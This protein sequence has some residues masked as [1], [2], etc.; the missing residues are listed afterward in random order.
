[1]KYQFTIK[2]TEPVAYRDGRTRKFRAQPVT[3]Q[4]FIEIDGK[5]CKLGYGYKSWWTSHNEGRFSALPGRNYKIF[6]QLM[7]KEGDVWTHGRRT[8]TVGKREGFLNYNAPLLENGLEVARI[9]FEDY[10]KD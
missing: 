4:V 5:E 2:T 3:L 7:P 10:Y 6:N 8:F 1:M 9:Y